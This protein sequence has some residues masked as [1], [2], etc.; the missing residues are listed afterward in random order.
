MRLTSKKRKPRKVKQVDIRT[1]LG[2]VKGWTTT[3]EDNTKQSNIQRDGHKYISEFVFNQERSNLKQNI[4]I[5][6]ADEARLQKF[7]QVS[8]LGPTSTH[9]FISMLPRYSHIHNTFLA[10]TKS[11]S[12][13]MSVEKKALQALSI[14]TPLNDNVATTKKPN[15][16]PNFL[17]KFIQAKSILKEARESRFVCECGEQI[18]VF[19]KQD[20]SGDEGQSAY[21]T[22]CGKCGKKFNLVL[23][24]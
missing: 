9:D 22:N 18:R 13:T 21:V 12:K 14:K 16:N 7:V 6:D 15:E 8:M 2:R 10:A 23:K 1:K 17:E 5:S 3:A 4:K 11:S 20:R 24:T 19:M